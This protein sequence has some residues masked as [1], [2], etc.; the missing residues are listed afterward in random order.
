MIHHW[1]L[2]VVTNIRCDIFFQCH[3]ETFAD[4]LVS[5]TCMNE[6]GR[7]TSGS[8]SAVLKLE[9]MRWPL[10]CSGTD[11]KHSLSELSS[12]AALFSN[13]KSSSVRDT[14]PDIL[15]Q[16][17]TLVLCLINCVQISRHH[18][19]LFA[20]LANLPTSMAMLSPRTHGCLWGTLKHDERFSLVVFLM[21]DS[22]KSCQKKGAPDSRQQRCSC[23][24][25]RYR[26]LVL[27]AWYS[28]WA[29]RSLGIGYERACV[30]W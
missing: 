7:G 26:M 29:C 1:K 20:T 10:E 19:I 24:T 23:D 28:K 14:E 27:I 15:F 25:G 4:E 17:L 2:A 6:S 16:L 11:I 5:D 30:Q 18:D 21:W 3:E 9:R 12:A 13:I 8:A 22:K